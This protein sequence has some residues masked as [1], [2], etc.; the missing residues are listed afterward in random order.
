MMFH[1]IT[2]SKSLYVIERDEEPRQPLALPGLG[3]RWRLGYC[4]NLCLYS[5][6]WMNA[7]TSSACTKLPPAFSRLPS[8]KS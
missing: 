8:Q 7:L 5:M 1:V 6:D 4:P 2:S 3:M